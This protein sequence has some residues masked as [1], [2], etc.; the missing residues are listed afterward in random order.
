IHVVQRRLVPASG[1]RG[2]HAG[3][4][5]GPGSR[6][7]DARLV[8]SLQSRTGA[9]SEGRMGARRFCC[10]TASVLLA[11]LACFVIGAGRSAPLAAAQILPADPETLLRA[12]SLSLAD[13]PGAFTEDAEAY[14]YFA[15]PQRS[16]ALSR[17]FRADP[18][19]TDQGVVRVLNTLTLFAD[20]LTA[21][22][23]VRNLRGMLGFGP[24]WHETAAPAVA[25]SSR[26][27]RL[28]APPALF[29]IARQ[30][31]LLLTL[32]IEAESA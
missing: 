10:I 23:A 31:N 22:Q 18:E 3:C 9:S 16:Y 19:A 27:F 32:L 21:E 24:D 13:L 12:M 29:L 30:S 14:Q 4:R 7:C 28:D 11:L 8:A 20:D 15:T 6:A 25:A 1:R 2:W 17:T 5:A 26:A